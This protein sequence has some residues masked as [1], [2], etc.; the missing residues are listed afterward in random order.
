VAA[1]GWTSAG[2]R[3]RQDMQKL[4]YD[5]VPQTLWTSDLLTS[6]DIFEKHVG[7]V[8]EREINYATEWR[9]NTL[10]REASSG[11]ATLCEKGPRD[12]P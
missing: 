10:L 1:V 11:P 2:R 6:F 12:K 9:W 7:G 3:G 4:N 8:N 5:K